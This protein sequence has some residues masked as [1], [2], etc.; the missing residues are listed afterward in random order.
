MGQAWEQ[1]TEALFHFIL[2]CFGMLYMPELGMPEQSEWE[3]TR[4]VKS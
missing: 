1:T 3:E 2:F 4:L